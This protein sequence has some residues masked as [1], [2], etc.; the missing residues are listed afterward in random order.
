MKS[1]EPFFLYFV[2]QDSSHKTPSYVC[3]LLSQIQLY[4]KYNPY[5]C[6]ERL[7]VFWGDNGKPDIIC[8]HP[9]YQHASQGKSL[10]YVVPV[11]NIMALH[12]KEF[13]DMVRTVLA[14]S[15]LPSIT[16]IIVVYDGHGFL[17]N[18]NVEISNTNNANIIGNMIM[19]PSITISET[20]LANVFQEYNHNPKLFIFSQ[21]GSMDLALRVMPSLSNTVIMT[22]TTSPN[23]CSYGATIFQKFIDL[24]SICSAMNLQTFQEARLIVTANDLSFFSSGKPLRLDFFYTSFASDMFFFVQHNELLNNFLT[25]LLQHS[26]TVLPDIIAL[27][28]HPVRH[29]WKPFTINH[30]GVKHSK[31]LL[32]VFFAIV[33]HAWQSGNM[34][35]LNF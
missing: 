5:G 15:C 26:P 27:V 7:H 10:P 12:Q 30:L 17:Y 23:V 8:H 20:F 31:E 19:T 25:H 33:S 35:C 28:P 21:C 16:P 6:Y 32:S 4:Q 22:S 9:K 24:L 2:G 1:V 11:D 3:T 29:Y 18:T 34:T 13:L 14:S